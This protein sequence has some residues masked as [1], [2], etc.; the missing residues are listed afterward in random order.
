VLDE[1]GVKGGTVSLAAEDAKVTQ[2]LR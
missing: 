1:T 2:Q